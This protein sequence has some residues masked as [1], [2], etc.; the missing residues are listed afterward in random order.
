MEQEEYAR[1]LVEIS[2]EIDMVKQRIIWI[3][4]RQKDSSKV[5][6]ESK[7]QRANNYERG[8]FSLD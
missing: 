1:K 7:G 8:F 4:S 6:N 5:G 2:E 3:L